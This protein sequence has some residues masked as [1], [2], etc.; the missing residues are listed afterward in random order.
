MMTWRIISMLTIEKLGQIQTQKTLCEKIMRAKEISE[1][2]NHKA[3]IANLAKYKK[4][5][6]PKESEEALKAP[7][8]GITARNLH[9]NYQ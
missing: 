8:T 2:P 9:S 1:Y 7:M 4:Y 3:T 6:I 5:L